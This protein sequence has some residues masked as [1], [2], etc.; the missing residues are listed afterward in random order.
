MSGILQA[1]CKEDRKE[2]RNCAWDPSEG[3]VHPDFLRS[4]SDSL[5]GICM[6]SRAAS[7]NCASGPWAPCVPRDSSRSTRGTP[8]VTYRA[9]RVVFGILAFLSLVP[10]LLHGKVR[11]HVHHHLLE[12]RNPL[13]AV[14]QILD[15]L[16][17]VLRSRLGTRQV[18]GILRGLRIAHASYRQTFRVLFPSSRAC[19]PLLPAVSDRFAP[20][21]QNIPAGRRGLR[22]ELCTQC[23]GSRQALRHSSFFAPALS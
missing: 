7:R 18:P 13:L 4:T 1:F 3:C 21:T 15:T 12:D 16:L 22:I 11:S 20:R 6:A 9:P 8:Q 10:V 2:L 14:R 5:R 23:R 19:E 17:H